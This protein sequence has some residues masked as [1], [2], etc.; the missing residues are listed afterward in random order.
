MPFAIPTLARTSALLLICCTALLQGCSLLKPTNEPTQESAAATTEV[1]GAQA[2]VLEVRAPDAIR[3][4]L[5]KHLELQRFR[6]LPDLQANELAQLLG[7]ADANAREML[8]AL[9]YFSPQ[10]TIDSEPLPTGSAAPYSV[11]LTVEPGPQTQVA[12]VKLHFNAAPTTPGTNAQRRQNDLDRVERNWTLPPGET[13]TQKAWDSAKSEGLRSLQRRRYPTASITDSRAE[14]DADHNRAALSVTYNTGPA[15]RF[16]AL[17]FQGA[18][19][20]DTD[21]ARR[22]ARLPV[23]A[24]YSETELLDAQQRLASSGY[25]DAVFLTL[26]TQTDDPEAATITAQVREAKLQKVVFGVGVST[27]SGAR[28]SVDHIHNRLPWLGWRAVSKVSV[29]RDAKLLDTE[30]VA[31]PDETN[32]RWFGG[33]QIKRELTGSYE[34]NSARLRG[35]MSQS[36]KNIDRNYYLQYDAANAQ[37]ENAPPESGAISMNYGWTGRY[38]NN[39]T[40]PTRGYGLGLELG[41]GTTLRNQ[42][43]PFVRARARWQ[44]FIPLG[45]VEVAEGQSRNTRLALR[46]EGGAVIA[47]DGAQIPV[48]QLFI[49][50]GD[51]TVRGY[52]YRTLGAYTSNDQLY[53]GRYLAVASAEWQRPIVVRGDATNWESAVFIDAGSVS[54]VAHRLEPK[55]GIGAGV[56]WRSPVGPLQAD[57]AWGVQSKELRLHLRLG[58]SF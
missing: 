36:T 50:G 48:T 44:T 27:D 6:E 20:Y 9:G 19:R 57:L 17:Q 41:V 32:W 39:N 4:V 38:F 52:G 5:E 51:T 29:D 56:R 35:G 14:V 15:F 33:A 26:D 24:E 1:S 58:F 55:V 46:A 43:D 49:T 45:K 8:G 53:G 7:S 10:I 21:G 2:F 31:L 25:Y 42:R 11:V 28:L 30:W 47:R 54:D 22:I 40:N 16:G 23:G 37:G 18:E 34:V 13:F 3:E 12:D